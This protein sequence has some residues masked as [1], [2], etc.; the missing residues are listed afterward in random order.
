MN[1][2]TKNLAGM[3]TAAALL[4]LVIAPAAAGENLI[5]NPSFEQLRD[6]PTQ[7]GHVFAEHAGWIYDPPGKMALGTIAHT[8]KY[9]YELINGNN[10][11]SRYSSSELKLEPGRY[12]MTAFIR[13]LGIVPM[14]S[15]A[16]DIHVC[17]GKY[18]P[19]KAP[20]TFGWSKVT[21]V[22]QLDKAND[23][24]IVQIGLLGGGYLWIDDISLEK[25][26]D[27]VAVTDSPVLDKEEAPIAPPD[28]LA[29]DAIRCPECGY[30]NNKDW[31][32][33][34]ACG[35]AIEARKT[36]D[37]PA[38]KVLFDFASGKP[39]PFSG[40]KIVTE[41]VPT[42][43]YGLMV[44]NGYGVC[45]K[46]QDWT[47]YDFLK[48]DVFNPDDAPKPVYIELRDEQTRDYWTRVNYSTV[49]APGKNTITIP[50]DIYVGEKSRPGRP[51]IKSKVNRLVL[52]PE[53]KTGAL[54]FSN[55]RLERLDT[56]SVQFD[57]L[58]AFSFGLPESPK[59]PAYIRVGAGVNYSA[60]RGYGWT[61]SGWTRAFDGFQP[62]A[63]FQTFMVMAD[64]TFQVDLPNGKYH[65]I[66]N[67]DCPGGF[68][69]EVQQYTSRQVTV[70]GK[71]AVDEKMTIDDFTKFY[72]RNAANEDLPG[73]DTFKQYVE[74]MF[75]IK[76]F[77]FDVTDGKA[78][79]GFKGTGN[80]A[81]TL[82]ALVIY[83]A[84][85]ADAGKKFWDWTTQQRKAQFN[86]YFK[87]IV[88]KAVGEKAPAEGY[89]LFTRGPV[90]ANANDGPR[91]EDAIPAGGLSYTMAKGEEQ[92][93]VFALQPGGD[94][95]E[96]DLK[97]SEFTGPSGAK[98]D[99][100]TFQPGWIDYRITRVTAEG[101]VYSVSPRYWRTLPAPAAKV[102]R[103]FWVRAKIAA[104]AAPGKYTGKITVKPANGQAKDVPVTMTVL[105]FALDPVTDIA[106]GPWGCGLYLPWAGND[107]KT[108]EWD[109]V[110][111]DKVLTALHDNG[112]T[113]VTGLPNIGVKAAGGKVTF[114]FARA[115][116]E[117]KALRDHGFGQMISSYGAQGLGYNMYGTGA[118]ADEAA[119][120][121]AGFADM[122][123]FLKAIYGGIEEHAAA[124]N[125]LPVAW[126]LCDEPL[127]PAAEASARNAAL[128]DK[129]ARD[130]KLKLQ[131]FMGATSL[132]GD[133]SRMSDEEKKAY[134]LHASL[135]GA[136]SMPSLNNH[137]EAA[138]KLIQDKGHKFSFYN[139]GTR[140]T[141]GR[142]MKALVLKY[143]L[144][145]RATWHLNAI[146][147]NPYYALDCREDD[148][149]F[150]NTN[151]KQELVPSLTLLANIL[152][153]VNDYRYLSTLQ[154]L[155]K[156]KADSPAAAE[157]RKVFDDQINLVAGKDR[158]G[159]KDQAG[160]DAD[161]QAVT[162]AILSLV[163]S[164]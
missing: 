114:D 16:L 101:S 86:D 119:A 20:E 156:E 15:A 98:L 102:T 28:K 49:A 99:A 105:P 21:Q 149:C 68:W 1:L 36:T 53:G 17:D 140:W 31:T 90:A 162:K 72:F 18:R 61:G 55:I 42:G 59:F 93:I 77:D 50:T 92:P 152:P 110:L 135:A 74:P 67:I 81:S 95:G 25:V 60:G 132:S 75:N 124:N 22:V 122:E 66:M 146:A 138:I 145:Y 5:K 41:N 120:K 163:E 14:Y 83:P 80:W 57:G 130:L 33:C 62:D 3:V 139:G 103:N 133:V 69:G 159:P 127:G 54:I 161:R 34:Y 148:Y 24:A 108:K 151:Q 142:Y 129:V 155:L 164:K 48:I 153:G 7:F 63:L 115:D 52:A 30:R 137:D 141:Y 13:G 94:L 154:R 29:A 6:R 37:G 47:G 58:Q 87:Q 121:A 9:S 27:S 123:S 43:K 73:L 84:D 131:T 70:N 82:S 89:V 100:K 91:P 38:V 147:G 96:I 65:A 134:N 64:A 11:K 157:A 104:D 40:G 39:D 76:Q 44:E 112:F 10:G 160:F 51:L 111:F 23:K 107:P 158:P 150:Y 116:A 4:A 126:N 125:W 35:T 117:M 109:A 136:L 143:G 88:P 26:D 71:P 56:Q 106:E 45:D 97:L 12:R 78:V 85:K 8:G 32:A 128:H 19:L 118:G 2:K 113:T 46:P 79:F 144:A